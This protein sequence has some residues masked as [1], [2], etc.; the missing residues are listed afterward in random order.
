M[1]KL[2]LLITLITYSNISYGQKLDSLINYISLIND[3]AK[4]WVSDSSSTIEKKEYLN[5]LFQK[6]KYLQIL[7]SRIAK[8]NVKIDRD[9]LSIILNEYS[10][11]KEE[12]MNRLMLWKFNSGKLDEEKMSEIISAYNDIL[13]S[14]SEI[15]ELFKKKEDYQDKL[16]T[17]IGSDIILNQLEPQT[18]WIIDEFHTLF[19]E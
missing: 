4:N 13:S 14:A 11:D 7:K 19:K 6:A 1:N 12:L 15:T 17:L 10:Q 16:T 18:Q 3:G 8:F 9:A 2:I 5:L